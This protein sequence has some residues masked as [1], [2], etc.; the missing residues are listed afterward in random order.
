MRHFL[1]LLTF[2]ALSCNENADRENT[3]YSNNDN[4]IT[5]LLSDPGQSSKSIS[6]SDRLVIVDENKDT[7][8][9]TFN[10]RVET[11]TYTTISPDTVIKRYKGIVVVPDPVE[12]PPVTGYVL[13][14][15]SGFDKSS[16]INTNQG[17]QNSISTSVFKTGPGSFKSQA[18]TKASEQSS[19]FRGEMQYTQSQTPAEGI[20]EYDVY[21]EDWRS[22]AGG[23][24]SVQWHPNS[25]TG[26]AVLSLQNY[27][28]SFNVVRSLSGTN[29]HQSGTLMKVE[30]NRWYNMRWENKFSTGSDGYIRLFIDGKLYYNFSGKTS[31]GGQYF[32]LGQNRWNTNNIN[33]VVYY[34]NLTVYK[35]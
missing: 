4:K 17:P 33:S 19:G 1:L 5:T 25:S 2:F 7:N 34:D 21:Y 13:L 9:I 26:G 10:Q 22:F 30:S 24:H 32:K 28:G 35:K 12:P 23:G 27:N 18:G 6:T 29:Y 15:Q 16:D 11:F 20:Y 14:Y 3:P 8:I 31:P